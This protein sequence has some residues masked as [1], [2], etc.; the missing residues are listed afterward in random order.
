MCQYIAV[1]VVV[2]FVR[3]T[4]FFP[5]LWVTGAL[6]LP[7]QFEPNGQRYTLA[8]I[9]PSDNIDARAGAVLRVIGMPAV[10]RILIRGR[11]LGNA[12]VHHHNTVCGLHLTRMWLDH[13]PHVGGWLFFLRQEALDVIMTDCSVQQRSQ[14]SRRR[15][16]EGADQIITVPIKEVAVFHTLSVLQTA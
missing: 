15:L 9:E 12:V 5:I 7:H 13:P 1:Y 2:G 11:L 8:V 16:P 4:L 10:H 3:A 6:H 14:A